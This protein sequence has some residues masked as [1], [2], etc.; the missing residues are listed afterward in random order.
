MQ[1]DQFPNNMH[2]WVFLLTLHSLD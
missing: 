1:E 2:V